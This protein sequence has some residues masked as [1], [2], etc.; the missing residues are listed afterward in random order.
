MLKEGSLVKFTVEP[1]S[2]DAP[3]NPPDDTT[4]DAATTHPIP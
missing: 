1:E 4:V 3:T 2:K